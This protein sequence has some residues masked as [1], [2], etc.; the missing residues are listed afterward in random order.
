VDMEVETESAGLS[1]GVDR[2]RLPAAR[3]PDT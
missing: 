3:S 1:H 2:S